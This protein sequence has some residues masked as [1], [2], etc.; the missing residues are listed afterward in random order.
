[1]T[2]FDEAFDVKAGDK[3]YLPPDADGPDLVTTPGVRPGLEILAGPPHNW[4]G[5]G[6]PTSVRKEMFR[7]AP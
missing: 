4:L 7:C 2:E 6:D 1:M 3:L 5:L